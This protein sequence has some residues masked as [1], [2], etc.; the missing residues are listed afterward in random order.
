MAENIQALL[1][2]KTHNVRE[3]G[4]GGS[5]IPALLRYGR[6]H[7]GT[8]C[9][10]NTYRNGRGERGVA[11]YRPF[12]SSTSS[13]ECNKLLKVTRSRAALYPV[14][15]ELCSAHAQYKRSSL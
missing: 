8:S 5:A 3:G 10:E 12:F 13:P 15:K 1:V 6:K 9:G 7:T 11:P 14:R 2:V 4:K